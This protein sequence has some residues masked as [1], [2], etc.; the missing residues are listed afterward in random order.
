MTTFIT[1]NHPKKLPPLPCYADHVDRI[2]SKPSRPS[3]LYRLLILP[4]LLAL[5]L[6]P[7]YTLACIT[8]GG[9][10]AL[11]S[12]FLWSA[13]AVGLEHDEEQNI[14]PNDRAK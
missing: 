6:W 7:A 1:E 3:P 10:I 2:L 12:W 9:P 11:L 8:I 4:V 14:G 5:W 13:R